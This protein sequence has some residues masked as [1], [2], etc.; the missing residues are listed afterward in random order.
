MP[1]KF[2][3]F[4]SPTPFSHQVISCPFGVKVIQQ[5]QRIIAETGKP[6][7]MVVARC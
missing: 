4:S 7:M 3:L 6:V 1:P 5:M 2:S